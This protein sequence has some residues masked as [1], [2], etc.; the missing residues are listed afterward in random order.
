MPSR[1]MDERGQVVGGI[2]E[3]PLAL[4]DAIAPRAAALKCIASPVP[5]VAYVLIAPDLVAANMLF[6]EME[7]FAN[8]SCADPSL[9]RTCSVEPQSSHGCGGFGFVQ[10]DP[11]L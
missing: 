3:G 4:D 9:M 10:T 6:K 11:L 1:K 7:D 5:G 2:V 8:A